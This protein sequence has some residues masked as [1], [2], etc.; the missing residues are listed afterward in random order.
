MEDGKIGIDGLDL[1]AH[2]SGNRAGIELS[3]KKD[4]DVLGWALIHA[5]VDMRNDRLGQRF[6]AS[7][8]NHADDRG[9]GQWGSMEQFAVS[10]ALRDQM[11]AFADRVLVWPKRARRGLIDDSNPGCILQVLIVEKTSVQ[12]RHPQQVEYSGE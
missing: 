2:L 4:D 3:A 10:I 12:Q 9:P 7:I 6:C 5:A 11:D 1:L 8:R